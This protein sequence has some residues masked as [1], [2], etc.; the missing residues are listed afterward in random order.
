[1]KMKTVVGQD[2]FACVAEAVR[3]RYSRLLRE[4]RGETTRENEEDKP[5][6]EELRT[7][8][9][10]PGEAF[11]KLSEAEPRPAPDKLNV[12]ISG[13]DGSLTLTEVPTLPATPS[14]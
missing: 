2:D 10:N 6:A 7:L 14:N 1:M 8:M 4:A 13:E 12:Y 5:L 11:P 3:R 9:K